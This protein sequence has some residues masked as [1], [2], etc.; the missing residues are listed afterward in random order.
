MSDSYIVA[1]SFTDKFEIPAKVAE[2]LMIAKE[3]G[4]GGVRHSN[5]FYASSFMWIQP[6]DRTTFKSLTLKQLKFAGE[7]ADWLA[8]PIHELGWSEA[9]AVDYSMKLVRRC[10]YDAIRDIWKRWA[11]GSYPSAKK[12]LMEA[13]QLDTELASEFP[14]LEGGEQ[15]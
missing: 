12:F 4:A 13:K 15:A 11:V 5:Q 10:H 7:I 1:Y 8:R 9:Q 6:K 3:K 14:M 2:A